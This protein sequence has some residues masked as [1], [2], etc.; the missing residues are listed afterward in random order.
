MSRTPEQIAAD[1]QLAAAIEAVDKAYGDGQ[2]D[3]D[4]LGDFIVISA[5][6]RLTDEGEFD[7]VTG[8]HVRDNAVPPYRVRGLVHSFLDDW[9]ADTIAA[10][11]AGDDE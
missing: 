4:V 9:R 3:G 2:V 5:W 1:E 8:H 6:S 10:V 7:T 11:L